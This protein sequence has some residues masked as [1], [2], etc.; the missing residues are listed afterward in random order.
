[1]NPSELPDSKYA[2]SRTRLFQMWSSAGDTGYVWA[3]GY[4]DAFEEW[5]EYLDEESPGLFVTVGEDELKEAADS[6]GVPWKDSWPDWNDSEFEKV[7]EE[8]ESDLDVIG[9]TSLKSG[10]HI[11]KD[12]WNIDEV[13]DEDEYSEVWCEC[14]KA[15]FEDHDE[16][17]EKPDQVDCPEA[18]G[19]FE[20]DDDLE[21]VRR[22]R[23]MP[24]WIRRGR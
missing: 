8:A 1:M 18:E 19:G 17:P 11:G 4:E 12:D 13:D 22:A 21:G 5:V 7:T 20:V 24:A 10:T 15:Y 6:L 9:H 14:A 2:A 16:W 23:F 3:D